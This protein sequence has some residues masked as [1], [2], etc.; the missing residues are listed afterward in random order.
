[1]MT[2]GLIGVSVTIGLMSLVAS[3]ADLWWMRV[4]MFFLGLSMAHVFVP[5]QAAAFARIT[6]ADTGRAST[7]FN[8]VR[9]LGSAVG[10]AV[11]SSSLA[12]VGATHVVGG[13][14]QPDLTAYH[15][16][17]LVAA[18]LALLAAFA[19]V[20]VH[21]DD[22]ESTRVRPRRATASRAA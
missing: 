5:A 20:T 21:D 6:V 18:G 14:I 13:R 10:V 8:A 16:T 19:A 4:L 17:F 2:G 3:R 15:V 9:Q 1:V 12:A 7:L 11:L 22:A